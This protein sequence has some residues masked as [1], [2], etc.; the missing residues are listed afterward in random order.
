MAKKGFSEVINTIQMENSNVPI[1]ETVETTVVQEVVEEVPAEET[2]VTKTTKSTKTAKSSKTTKEEKNEVETKPKK[3]KTSFGTEIKSDE[4]ETEVL[5][6]KLTDDVAIAF[7]NEKILTKKTA[8]AIAKEAL[9]RIYD[10]ENG[11]FTIDIPANKKMQTKDTS[12]NL[13]KEIKAAL[14]DNAKARNMKTY[15]YFNKLMEAILD[16]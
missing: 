6:V 5:S 2:K 16:E 3:R 14:I 11:T 15:E 9:E 10:E 13:P 7:D 1:E 4:K 12:F 8:S